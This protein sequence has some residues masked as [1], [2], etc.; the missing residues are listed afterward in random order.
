MSSRRKGAIRDKFFAFVSAFLTLGVFTVYST[1]LEDFMREFGFWLSLPL[2]L[3]VIVG[4]FKTAYWLEDY[5]RP[6]SLPDIDIHDDHF[7]TPSV[8][9]GDWGDRLLAS[10]ESVAEAMLCAERGSNRLFGIVRDDGAEFI[11]I[12]HKDGWEVRLFDGDEHSEK[13]ALQQGSKW[14]GD[15][16]R[17]VT[18]WKAF[19]Q[20]EPEGRVDDS[21]TAQL[22]AHFIGWDDEPDQIAWAT[23]LVKD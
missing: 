22:A 16:V 21:T 8:K 20:K 10:K 23:Y 17:P 9:A 12:W 18:F 1:L 3:F 15:H 5:I 14:A 11:A 2:F 4:V 6:K 13:L 19:F 7:P